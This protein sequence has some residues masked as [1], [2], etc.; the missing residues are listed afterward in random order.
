MHPQ[1]SDVQKGDKH[2]FVPLL[3]R[4]TQTATS[5]YVGHTRFPAVGKSQLCHYCAH[6]HLLHK[7]N[8]QLLALKWRLHHMPASHLVYARGAR[9]ALVSATMRRREKTGDVTAASHALC[10]SIRPSRMCHVHLFKVNTQALNVIRLRAISAV[11]AR[12]WICDS[13]RAGGVCVGVEKM[14]THLLKEVGAVLEILA[15]LLMPKMFQEDAEG[16]CRM[17]LSAGTAGQ[18]LV[19]SDEGWGLVALPS[20]VERGM[21]MK[22]SG[23]ETH[24]SV[25]DYAADVEAS[26]L[27]TRERGRG[28]CQSGTGLNDEP[29]NLCL[30][31]AGLCVAWSCPV[32]PTGLSLPSPRPP[33]SVRTSNH[34]GAEERR[35]EERRG[36]ERRRE[37]RMDTGCIVAARRDLGYCAPSNL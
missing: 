14:S 12:V 15:P 1:K 34:E 23:P 28:S 6:Q 20:A 19:L 29:H 22:D 2:D 32:A 24:S 21:L 10:G 16:A 33:T 25:I 3:G 27:E 36:E 13:L 7:N 5:L 37:E 18:D 35:G 4:N 17:V 9:L 30:P 26:H 8:L 11:T 31:C